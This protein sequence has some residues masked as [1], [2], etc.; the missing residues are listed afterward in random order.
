MKIAFFHE[1]SFGGA[2][3]VCDAYGKMLGKNHTVDVYYVDQQKDEHAEKIFTNAFFFP[4]VSQEQ[5][6]GQWQK[7]LYKDTVEL[8]H[9]SILHRKIAQ[10]I[11]QKGYDFVFINPS[12][13]TQAP[14]I[15]RFLKT[16]NVYFCQEPLRIVYDPFLRILPKVSLPKRMYEIGVRSL[17]KVVD[18]KNISFANLMLANSVFSKAWIEKAYKK[19]SV[20]CYL[21][22]DANMFTPLFIQKDYDVLFLGQKLDIEGYDLLEE[23]IKFF[24]K[25]PNIKI[26]ERNKDGS[27]IDDQQLV[28]EY[29]KAKIVV[30]LSRHEPFG[31]TV[32]EA[33][34]CGVSVVAV[35]EGGFMESVIHGKTGFL[36][37][38]DPKKLFEALEKLLND[39]DL[40]VAMGK[41]GRA[42]ILKHW[43]WEKSVR[44]FLAIITKWK[45]I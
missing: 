33:M 28:K 7:R 6:K 42:E 43:T 30:C 36:V 23:A 14:F 19:E 34:S 20:V 15:L 38:R 4:F 25:Q 26:I 8:L 17:R 1:L 44:R 11:D 3:R 35:K 13:F 12:K 37:K 9:L 21:G 5:K 31:L 41:N 22:V 18:K 40:Q 27:G 32:L 29:N 39:N 16:P 2:R 45:K 10:I 24:K